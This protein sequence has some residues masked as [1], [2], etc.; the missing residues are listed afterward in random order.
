MPDGVDGILDLVGGD[1][2]KQVASLAKDQ[3]RIVSTAD[4]QTAA[5]LGG[6]YVE[7]D[8][9]GSRFSEL[10]ALVADG[11][12]DPHAVDVVPFDKAAEAVAAVESGHSQGKVVIEL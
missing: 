2:L 1:A 5:E 11:K 10:A 7:R 9:S 3:E 6:A 12:L 4:P 8:P